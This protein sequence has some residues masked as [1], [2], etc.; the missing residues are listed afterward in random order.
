MHRH[1][2]RSS[3]AAAAVA[4]LLA[5]GCGDDDEKADDQPTDDTPADSGGDTAAYCDAA[6]AIETLP[7]PD[8]DFENGTPEE[9]ASGMKAFAN[10]DM[11]PLVDDLVAVAPEELADE[12]EVMTAA[13]DQLASTGDF[14]AFDA[15]E[16]KA[17]GSTLHAFDLANCGW[18]SVE[19]TT[20][21]YGFEGLPTS[22]PAGVTSFDFSN[23]GNDVHELALMRKNDG[24]TESAEEL[25]ALGEEEASTKV[26]F[27][28][29]GGPIPAGESEYLVAELTRGDYVA[30]CFLPVGMTAMDG[31]PPEGPPHFTQGMVSEFTVE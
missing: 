20:V 16:A 12:I 24:V 22:L 15:P 7:P 17:A 2:L 11:K 5:A 4:T 9:I 1:W 14:A 19:L 26:T 27:L 13:L 21:D 8:V 29:A 3:L 28:G 31:P 30:V 23:E 10:E 6:L 25:L 18:E